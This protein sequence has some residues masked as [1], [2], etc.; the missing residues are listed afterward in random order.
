VTYTTTL[1]AHYDLS[2]IHLIGYAYLHG[3]NASSFNVLNSAQTALKM[4]TARAG[5]PAQPRL[6][7]S[8]SPNPSHGKVALQYRLPAYEQQGAAGSQTAQ[9]VVYDATGRQAA[10]YALS[11]TAGSA[12][13]EAA[14][15]NLDLG[16]LAPGMY[17]LQLRVGS[18]SLSRKLLLQP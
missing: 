14:N 11:A 15:K 5:A 8:V 16:G 9:L 13:K 12:A 3:S 2:Q 6:R 7:F 18:H 1:P 17:L 10:K 4:S